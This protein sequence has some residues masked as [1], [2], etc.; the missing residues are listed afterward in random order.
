MARDMAFDA[1]ARLGPY[2]IL[3]PLGAGGMGAV[4]RARDTRLDRI[5]AIK[6][7]SGAFA[8]DPESRQRF[9]AEARAIAALNDP[10]IC[11]IHDVGREGDLDYLVLEYLEGETLADRIHRSGALPISEALT[12]AV[13]IGD[14]LDRA[15]RASIV[16]R[17]LK[18]GNAMLVARAGASEPTVK[19]LDFG[20]ASR[21]TGQRPR[22]LD[23]ALTATMAPSMVATRPPSATVQSATSGMSGTVQYMSPEQLDGQI[24][25]HR[26]D[27]F[28]FGCVLYEMLAGRKAFEAGTA[29]TAIAAIISSEP[30]AIP[31]L[32]TAHPLI[33]HILRRCLEK[34]PDRRWQNIGDVT[35][36]L[37]WVAAQPAPAAAVSGRAKWRPWHWAAAAVL[38]SVLVGLPL[39]L[40]GALGL[41][42]GGS[43]DERGPVPLQL[44]VTTP[45]TDDVSGAIAPDGSQIA[46]VA[47]KDHVPVLWVRPLDSLESRVLIGTD[48]ASFPFWSPDGKSLG[49]FADNKLKRIEV[50]GGAPIVITDAPTARGGA[51]GPDGTILFA[52]GV[53]ASI[54]RVPARGGTVE[55]V[56]TIGGKF[57]SSHRRPELPAGRTAFPLQLVAW[58]SRTPTVC[59]SARSTSRRPCASPLKRSSGSSHRPIR[60]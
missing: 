35:G 57:G 54:K 12:I 9:E 6:V 20:L 21:A 46:Y 24:P 36:E 10:H 58:R 7:L 30:P 14:A 29:M 18:P 40:L 33:D 23:D 55:E 4:Y 41:L 25:D 34:N 43:N 15:H 17:D 60:C 39:G 42:N 26:A 53:N 2:E 13:Q 52:P 19:L 49:F 48:G 32:A 11:T 3:S 28:A 37:R 1:G 50:A 59:T 47:I 27:I 5:V 16:H 31:A 8:A 22:G 45:P 44:E 38:V 56:T 51:W